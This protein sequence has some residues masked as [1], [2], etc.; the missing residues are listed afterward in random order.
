MQK[1]TKKLLEKEVSSWKELRDSLEELANAGWAFRGQANASWQLESS[2]T[3][4][5]KNF[6]GPPTEWAR[7]EKRS[8]HTFKRKAHILLPRT[9]EEGETL[10]WLALMQHHG[11]PTRLLDFSWSPYV[12]AFFAL[13][14]ATTDAAIWAICSGRHVPNFRG[15]YISAI[16]NR[17][18]ELEH[19]K[20]LGSEFR[21]AA[22]AEKIP[23]CMIGEPVLM[24]QRMI[25]QAGT[26][27]VPSVRID[28]P[29]ESLLPPASVFKLILRT[30]SLRK[31]TMNRLYSMNINNAALF[32]GIDGLARSLA[33]ELEYEWQVDPQAAR[34]LTLR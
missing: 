16:L 33:F 29:I 27:L 9:P 21:Q 6:G 15:F 12:A 8:L 2:L 4:Y 7:R 10:E 20:T 28:T 5:L 14:R 32:P 3:R 25:T 30:K 34:R 24:N 23:R 1:T 18:M 26:F 11:T 22:D 19:S 17:T 31:D 13:E